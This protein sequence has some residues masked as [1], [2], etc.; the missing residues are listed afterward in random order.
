LIGLQREH[1]A[2]EK[3]C[4]DYDGERANPDVIHLR[5]GLGNVVRLAKEAPRSASRQQGHFLQFKQK[6]RGDV[7]PELSEE[8]AARVQPSR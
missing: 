2:G 1:A 3:A 5:D 8:N 7:H 6:A 4:E